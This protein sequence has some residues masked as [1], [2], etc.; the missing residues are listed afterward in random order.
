MIKLALFDI[1]GTLIVDGSFKGRFAYAIEKVFGVKVMPGA[2]VPTGITE[3]ATAMHMAMPSGITEEQFKKRIGDVAAAQIEFVRAN[4]ATEKI[5]LRPGIRE[6]LTELKN[7]GVKLGLVTGGSTDIA[8][9][10]LEMAGIYAMFDLGAFGDKMVTRKEL[11]LEVLSDF[12]KRFDSEI[13]ATEIMYFGDTPYDVEGAHA[14]GLR[15]IA[16]GTD[17]HP[18]SELAKL[19]ADFPVDDLS[20]NQA[21][22]KI[23]EQ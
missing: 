13:A 23:L 18:A 19:G 14:A 11:I 21:V 7:R 12:R 2:V 9:I 20:D 8:R 5:T 10:K 3:P 17:R 4:M 16:T 1:D 15:I 22:L 6:L